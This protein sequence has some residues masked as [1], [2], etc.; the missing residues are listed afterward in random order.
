M[1]GPGR[2]RKA[3]GRRWAA[4]AGGAVVA[5]LLLVALAA[6]LIA[7]DQPIACRHAGRLHFP[8]L[9]ACVE[10]LPAIGAA[11][12]RS[13]PFRYPGFD[14]KSEL[15][16]QAWAIWPMIPYG[17]L[18]M[19]DQTLSPPSTRHWLGTD[20]QGRDVAA[21][22]V[23][24]AAVSVQVGLFAM[25]MAG[26]IGIAVG[27][28]AGYAGGWPDWLLSRVIEIVMCFPAF[29]L[30][31]SVVVWLEPRI[32][33]VIVVIALTQW[34]ATA[35][36]VRAEVL[37][38]KQA[39]YVLAAHS[40]GATPG[41]VLARHILPGALA[42]VIVT[43][44]FGVADAVMLEAALSWVGFGVPMPAPS[45]GNMLRSAYEQIR[46]A[47]YLVYPPCIAIFISVLGYHLAGEALRARLD[48]Q[49]N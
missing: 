21:R 8:A 20:D 24:G 46:S 18:E 39:D 49:R 41:R 25:L 4:W 34:T 9:V 5:V 33:H 47:P 22:L 45:W 16:P 13:R 12:R 23:H 44:T 36:L 14:A 27:G 48:P 26:A 11:V 28:V 3:A 29:F 30:I 31:L 2:S 15:D 10:N 43:L 32:G 40:A 19:S 17:P 42:P 1:N 35:R 6:P 37:R 7:F 38:I